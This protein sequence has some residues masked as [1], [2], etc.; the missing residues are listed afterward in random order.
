MIFLLLISLAFLLLRIQ[1]ELNDCAI[2]VMVSSSCPS[3]EKEI[4]LDWMVCPHCLQR[5]RENCSSC[6]N[7][8]LISHSFCPTCGCGTEVAIG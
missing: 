1:D 3:C 4:S 5:L 8:K 2:E 7:R 6:N